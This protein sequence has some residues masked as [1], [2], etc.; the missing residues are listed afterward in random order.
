[1]LTHDV[2]IV[3]AGL[4]GM[5]A[6][7]EVCD[8]YDTAIITKVYP[9]RSH[10][11][12]AQGGVA[13]SLANSTDDSWEIHMY[14]T[15]K[16]SDFL[17][18][19]DA[20]EMMVKD[21]PKAIIEMEH[22][23]C[24]FSRTE[25]GRIAQREFGGHSRPRACY[26]A[27]RTGHALLHALYEQV[28]KKA[29][30]IKIYSEWYV[31]SLII[32]DN[33]CKGVV[34]YDIKTG[35][36]EVLRGKA[37]MFAT[38]GYGRAFSITSN[39]FAS[40]GD[41]I[42]AA[43]RA[44]IPLEDMEFVQFHPTGLYGQGIL[45]SEAARGEG[46]Y[47]VN[48]KGE[49]FMEKYAKSK[50]ELA[51]RDIVSRSEQNEINEGRG[52]DGKDYIYLDLRHLGRDKI[53]E[54][55]P[56]VRQLGIDFIGVDCIEKPIPIQPT[57]HYSMGGIPADKDGQ[58]IID[59]KGTKVTGFFAAGECACVSVHGANRLGTNSLLDALVFGRR[60][61]KALMEFAGS[62]KLYDVNEDKEIASVRSRIDT[63]INTSGTESMNNIRNELKEIMMSNCG[64]FRNKEGLEVCLKK[65][66]ELQGRFKK[67]K[68]TDRGKI[69]N[70][71]VIE[72]IELGHML[73]YSEVIIV[74]AMAREESRGSHARTDFPKRDDAKWLKHTLSYKK[75]DGGIELKYK[76]VTITKHQP[77]ERKY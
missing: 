28:M 73:E 43:Y 77:E 34:T 66:K 55:L 31:L 67:A 35:K 42:I 41:G 59:D 47:L 54:K 52:I 23:G 22:M 18:D 46:G 60:T 44:G 51:P 37:V 10:S 7:L 27:D 15:V 25:D 50:L 72:S 58:V 21:A 13:A 53:M 63:I 39:A 61:G 40:T 17:G 36:L 9:T 30:K 1:M 2:I 56:Q 62:A 33:V 76:P 16:G 68:I 26:A 57:A 69:F 19:Q 11:G 5:R 4:A 29:N 12:A 64:V 6:A 14:D 38:G 71:E 32:E 45:V 65:V 75:P 8:R 3:G 24:V 20:I 49:R 48:G 74:S 70:T